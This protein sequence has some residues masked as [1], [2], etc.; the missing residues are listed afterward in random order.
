MI[1]LRFLSSKLTIIPVDAH[2][3]IQHI[4]FMLL[5]VRYVGL[6]DA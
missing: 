6:E 3:I 1:Y 2:N 4:C 5:E